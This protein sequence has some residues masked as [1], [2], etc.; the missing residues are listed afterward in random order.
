MALRPRRVFSLPYLLLNRSLHQ[1]K[2]IPH[3][4]PLT[5]FQPSSPPLA[6][7]PPSSHH[8]TN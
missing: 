3:I 1:P 6:P 2:S 7:P 5:F 8:P 4:Y